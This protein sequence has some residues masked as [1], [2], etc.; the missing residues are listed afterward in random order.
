MN[1]IDEIVVRKTSELCPLT[2]TP[3]CSHHYTH[4]C[5]L[6]CLYPR[7]HSLSRA[8]KNQSAASRCVTWM[9]IGDCVFILPR[10]PRVCVESFIVL[11]V[12]LFWDKLI[13][14][15]INA[16]MPVTPGQSDVRPQHL[17]FGQGTGPN[18]TPAPRSQL[19]SCSV[20]TMRLAMCE[21]I[22]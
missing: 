8:R 17:F 21:H 5:Y 11:H 15:R 19:V 12:L 7:V 22:Q 13:L 14:S 2:F 6:A 1:V 16:R 10:V 20:H 4:S 9:C 3:T 18:V